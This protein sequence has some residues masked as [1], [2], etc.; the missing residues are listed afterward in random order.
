MISTVVVDF[1]RIIPIWPCQEPKWPE[2]GCTLRCHQTW[3]AG[4]SLTNGNVKLKSIYK[5]GTSH[6]LVW[7][8]CC[9]WLPWLQAAMLWQDLHSR[10]PNCLGTGEIPAVQD[11]QTGVWKPNRWW[12]NKRCVKGL[13]F[14]VLSREWM[15]MGVAGMIIT[16][17]YGSF[18]HSPLST[19]LY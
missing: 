13:I 11:L 8:H 14:L 2:I 9:G 5:K 10:S 18:P 6:C 7:L 19:I 1:C 4:K 16:S 12:N 17:D 3:L 15:G